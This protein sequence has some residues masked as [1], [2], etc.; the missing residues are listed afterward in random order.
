MYAVTSYEFVV[1]IVRL[2]G[3]TDAS[4]DYIVPVEIYWNY[5]EIYGP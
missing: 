4:L 2:S 5:T 1:W 3:S